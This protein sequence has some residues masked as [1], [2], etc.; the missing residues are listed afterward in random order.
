MFDLAFRLEM[1]AETPALDSKQLQS[2][3]DVNAKGKKGG[4]IADETVDFLPRFC[5]PS[6]KMEANA[7]KNAQK[8]RNM[9]EE[10]VLGGRK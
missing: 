2:V 8:H 6:V 5:F 9:G 1:I 10:E 7:S 3:T 4:G